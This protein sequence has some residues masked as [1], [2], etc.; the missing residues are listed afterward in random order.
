VILQPSGIVSYFDKS[1]SKTIE[2]YLPPVLSFLEIDNKCVILSALKKAEEG[3]YLVLRVYNISSVPQRARLTFFKKFSIKSV[4][5][6]NFLEEEPQGDIKAKIESW[7]ENELNISLE[8][9]VIVTF[10]IESK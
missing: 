9:H 7:N 3:N 10:K 5:I 6:V 8:P 4:K 1:T 2:S